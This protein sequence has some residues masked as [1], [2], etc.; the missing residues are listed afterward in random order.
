MN[1]YDEW[2]AMG[3]YVKKGEKSTSRNAEGKALFKR[4]QVKGIVDVLGSGCNSYNPL[5]HSDD[6]M[7]IVDVQMASF[8]YIPTDMELWLEENESAQRYPDAPEFE[9]HWT[10][11]RPNG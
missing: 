2:K 7:K 1:T 6:L 5:S 10:Q 4:S 3:L 9:D 8:G 11:L